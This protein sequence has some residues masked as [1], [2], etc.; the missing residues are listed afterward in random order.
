[1]LSTSASNIRRMFEL[2]GQMRKD[3]GG[4]V[5]DLSLGNPSL[6]PPRVWKDALRQ[7]LDDE[8]PGKHRYMVN[9][10][11][12]E[13]RAFIAQR[14]AKRYGVAFEAQ[15]VVMTTG[16]AAAVNVVFTS[17]LN[18]EDEVLVPAPYFTEYDNYCAN[19]RAR[20]VSVPSGPNFSLDV[21]ALLKAAASPQARVIMLNSPNNP[22]GAIYSEAEL[23][24]LAQGLKS[25]A[26]KRDRPLYVIED[27]PYR[28]LVFDGESAPSILGR[29]DD[30]IFLSSHSKDIGLAGER[31]GYALVAPTC[32]GREL[33]HHALPFFNRTLG[34]VNAPAL[35]Q[36]SL[37]LVLSHPEGRVDVS[38]YA[39]NCKKMAAALS[40]LGYEL[41]APR[42]GFFLFP[43]IPAAW[44]A[45]GEEGDALLTQ[46]LAAH[47]VIA[48]P[49]RAFGAPGYLR[50]SMCVDPDLVDGAIEA[51]RKAHA[52]D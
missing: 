28:D 14:E 17:I 8:T 29:Y 42:A 4:P 24:S 45:K 27:S 39:N 43:R 15:D 23:E 38:I 35:M 32:S 21:D 18:P 1:M 7:L 50:I 20:L 36:R 11:F 34:F 40:E 5:Y 6:E 49:G 30:V 46:A 25:L 10:G 48:V 44:R 52:K 41:A 12:P 51:F 9:A 13:V 22:T 31:I 16:A 47:R 33:L 26:A 2:A 37:P 3:G 19:A